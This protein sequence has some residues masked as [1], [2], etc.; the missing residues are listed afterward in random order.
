MK[1]FF[2]LLSFLFLSI[3]ANAQEFITR[4]N[5]S[6]PSP[7]T[8]ISFGIATTGPVNYTWETI[9]A[10]TNGSGSL[11]GSTATIT[12]L[13]SGATIR[14]KITPT[15]FTRF[16]IS[17]FPNNNKLIDVEQWGNVIWATMDS[18]FYY[19]KNLKIS[20]TDLPNLSSLISMKAMF[21]GCD[22]LNGPAN[23]G[24]WNTSNVQYMNNMFAY[25]DSFNKNIGSWNTSSVLNMSD[26][27]LGATAFNQNIGAWN[28]SSVDSMGNMFAYATSF[29][30]NIGSWNT[31]NVVNMGGMFKDATSFNQNIGSWDVSSVQYMNYMFAYASSF[32]QNIGSWNTAS[33][34]NLG[35]MFRYASS[36]NQNIGNWNTSLVTTMS[37]MFQNATSFNQN[38][39]SWQ[40]NPTVY[41][42]NLFDT[43][44][45]SCENYSATLIGWSNNPNCPTGTY[46]SA[47]TIK[48][49]S[50]AAAQ[51]T[52]LDINKGWTITGDALSTI[53]CSPTSSTLYNTT[54]DLQP[55]LSPNP[56]QSY[57][58]LSI[59][60]NGAQEA[61]IVVYNNLGILVFEDK[62]QLKRGV[63]TYVIHTDRYVD[64]LYTISTRMTRNNFVNRL[65][66]GNR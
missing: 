18:A 60:S 64:G 17:G 2:Y 40:L 11:S 37:N 28:T 20:A 12:G 35:A 52:F 62:I 19:C 36:F 4:W 49:G 1:S 44:G 23:I 10:G 15:N 30:Q 45:I 27:F 13:P 22:S 58:R 43:S 46:L 8:Q 63:N 42:A 50:H 59:S 6:L 31:S 38:I 3:Q 14:L 5:L 7:A 53:D 48:Y 39:G 41:L 9:P 34:L 24:S 55:I 16:K 51:R 54:E 33:V 65:Q 56:A 26:M 29:N 47:N 25:C 66:I 21:T 61:S 32:N 57:T